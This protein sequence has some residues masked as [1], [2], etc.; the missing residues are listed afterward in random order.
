MISLKPSYNEWM[1]DGEII[2]VKMQTEFYL[3]V[4]EQTR[5]PPDQ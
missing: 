4:E 5:Q 1:N 3:G 2:H